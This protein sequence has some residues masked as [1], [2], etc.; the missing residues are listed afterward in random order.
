MYLSFPR[1]EP[2]P[3]SG[4]EVIPL[5]SKTL[6]RILVISDTHDHQKHLENLP[7]CDIFIHCGDILLINQYF[8]ERHS[9]LKLRDFNKWLESVPAK[10]RIVICG[11]HDF[12]MEKLGKDAVQSILTNCVYLVNQ[13]VDFNGLRIWG[14][15]LS[16]GNS[17]NKAYQSM[18]FQHET[19]AAAP[20]EVDIL[21]T[22]GH[23]P[24]L[25]QK[26]A[27]RV[28]FW[29][30]AHNAYGIRFPGQMLRGHLVLSLSVSA[31]VMDSSFSVRHSP[32]I[33]DIPQ[34][35]SIAPPIQPMSKA[36]SFRDVR[37]INS[38]KSTSS[39]TS[40]ILNPNQDSNSDR[41][42][43]IIGS[44]RFNF[45]WKQWFANKVSPAGNTLPG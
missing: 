37:Q 19:V 13:G 8:D 34:Q 9:R 30:H 32:I 12:A 10:L 43:I 31:S 18:E 3:I 40:P 41:T 38:S 22:H 45:N 28:H 26:I 5:N 1:W 42:C 14:S 23:C 25:E 44:N 20:S 27:H 6:F 21:I 11:N 17:P 33:V 29:G 7:E 4:S 39:K 36:M 16:H 35:L 15:P 2:R 24:E